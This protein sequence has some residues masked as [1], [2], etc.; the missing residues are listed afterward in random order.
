MARQEIERRM[1]EVAPRLDLTM[2][3]ECAECGREFSA[4]FD[5]QSFFF[6]ELNVNSDLLYREVHQLA[7]HYHWSE[8]EIME[9]PREKRSRYLALLAD[10]IDRLNES[11]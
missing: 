9:M 11:A 10:E 4:P 1:Q 2:D 8:S 7:F 6:G 3:A 5:P